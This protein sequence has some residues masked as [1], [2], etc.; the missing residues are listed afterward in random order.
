MRGRVGILLGAH[1]ALLSG[2]GYP[3]SGGCFTFHQPGAR[4]KCR[5][6]SWFAYADRLLSGQRI[7]E[8]LD[9]LLRFEEAEGVAPT[10]FCAIEG[11]VGFFSISRSGSCIARGNR[12]A[13]ARADA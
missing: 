7:D 2:S 1:H 9:P 10:S 13:D 12:D 3:R 11:D 4:P 6:R 5:R 8:V